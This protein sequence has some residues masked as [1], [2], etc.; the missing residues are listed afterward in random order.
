MG[1]GNMATDIIITIMTTIMTDIGTVG[2]TTDIDN[3]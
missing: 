1:R 3:N 2:T